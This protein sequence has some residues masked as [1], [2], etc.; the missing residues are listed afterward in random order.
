MKSEPA[1][2]FAIHAPSGGKRRGLGG[3]G[4]HADDRYLGLVDEMMDASKDDDRE[5]F[6]TAL[7]AYVKLC[8]KDLMSKKPNDSDETDEEEDY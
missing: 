6:N 2:M 5:M 7:A 3:G 4:D 8:V 1:V